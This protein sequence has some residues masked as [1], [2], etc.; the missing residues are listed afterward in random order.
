M[1]E[2]SESIEEGRIDH[3]AVNTCVG[4]HQNER[5]DEAEDGTHQHDEN[6]G[7]HVSTPFALSLSLAGRPLLTIP[8]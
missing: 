1:K 2:A 4:R 7:F 8:G 6:S 3:V 5:E